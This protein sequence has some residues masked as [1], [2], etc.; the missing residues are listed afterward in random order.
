MS[1]G[2]KTEGPWQMT[3]IHRA[4][5]IQY[6]QAGGLQSFKPSLEAILRGA[7]SINLP[8]WF[9]KLMFQ[10]GGSPCI[11]AGRGQ[12]F[13]RLHQ[14]LAHHQPTGKDL[15]HASQEHRHRFHV[16]RQHWAQ[17]QH[18]TCHSMGL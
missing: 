15:D 16:Q 18:T 8:N 13:I 11:Q 2:A 14:D 10:L 6:C 17:A 3:G 1:S 12:L 7:A 9:L 4:L 5:W